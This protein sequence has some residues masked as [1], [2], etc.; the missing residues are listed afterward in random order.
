MQK[1]SLFLVSLF[2]GLAACDRQPVAPGGETPAQNWMNNE[3]NGNVRIQRFGEDFAIS[4]TDPRTGLR[5]THTTFPIPF[6]GEAELHCG[7]QG[8]LDPLDV[9]DVGLFVEGDEF[10]LSWLHRNERGGLWVIIRDVTQ[11]GD[12]YGNKLIA[13]GLGTMHYTDN[14]VFGFQPGDKNANAWGFGASGVLTTPDNQQL[15]YDGHARFTA[16]PQLD[17]DGFPIFKHANFLVNVH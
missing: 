7:P 6:N 10:F 5:A 12:C 2:I 11:S 1:Y 3:D 15:R 14:D 16:G 13:E 9:Q 8:V 17:D 4:W